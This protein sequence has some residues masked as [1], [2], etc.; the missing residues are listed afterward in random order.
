M[1]YVVPLP[2]LQ[3][4]LGKAPT[5]N[6][7]VQRGIYYAPHHS[8]TRT[9]YMSGLGQDNLSVD[10]SYLI[11]G[12]AALLGAFYLLGGL[13]GGAKGRKI[14]RYASQREA[15]NKKIKALGG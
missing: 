15:L 8:T 11:A 13:K 10:P 14:A 9:L 7:A 3:R 2:R 5:L 12:V 4:G 1:A 6:Q